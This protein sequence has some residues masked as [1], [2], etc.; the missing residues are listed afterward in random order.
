MSEPD[1]P[2]V[3]EDIGKKSWLPW[4]CAI[5]AIFVVAVLVALKAPEWR[6][7]MELARIERRG[8][9]AFQRGEH[10]SPETCWRFVLQER[11]DAA[12]ARNKLVVLYM[13][14][15]RFGEARSLLE[16]GIR[17][18]PATTSFHYN[19]ALLLVAEGDLHGALRSLAQV[20]RMNPGHGE[21]HFLKGV[22]YEKLGSDELARKEFV[23]ELNIDP[24]KLAAWARLVKSW[25][26]PGP[27]NAPEVFGK[28]TR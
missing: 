16:S 23:Q 21:V 26:A 7:R 27:D 14:E 18:N 20:Q 4:S 22:I 8:D 12:S 15:G 19:F 5:A 13:K 6:R 25:P 28:R 24:A 17:R 1:R 10:R 3:A 11:P 2:R 9:L